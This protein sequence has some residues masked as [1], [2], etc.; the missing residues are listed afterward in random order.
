MERA[1]RAMM[2]RD[3]DRH[4]R[5]ER[6]DRLRRRWNDACHAKTREEA[7]EIIEEIRQSASLN[8][9]SLSNDLTI[10]EEGILDVLRTKNPAT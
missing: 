2:Q 3:K 7:A 10:T 8:H 4:R 5:L 6:I 9:L 1:G